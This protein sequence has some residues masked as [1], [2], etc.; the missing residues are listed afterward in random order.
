[1]YSHFHFISD[2]S[3]AWIGLE[4][5]WICTTVKWERLDINSFFSSFWFYGH[6]DRERTVSF[7][8]GL[9]TYYTSTHTHALSCPRYLQSSPSH[10]HLSLS[11]PALVL[12]D[13]GVRRVE[14]TWDFVI[15]LW[16]LSKCMCFHLL[17]D[18]MDIVFFKGKYII[19]SEKSRR[20]GTP[21]LE[22]VGN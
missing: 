3:K 17:L 6:K 9:Y 20:N 5:I 1:M 7:R 8:K 16:Q 12:Y 15:I 18:R 21:T 13:L 2:K 19:K 4:L 14:S 11:S 22:A 10:T